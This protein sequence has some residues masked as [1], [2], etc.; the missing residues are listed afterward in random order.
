MSFKSRREYTYKILTLMDTG[1]VSP[2]DLVE[3]MAFWCSEADMKKLYVEGPLA[4]IRA[5][6]LDVEF[7]EEEV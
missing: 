5:A 6:A 1:V 4:E 3:I 2:E 7:P